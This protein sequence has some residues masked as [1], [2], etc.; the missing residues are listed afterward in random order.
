MAMHCSISDVKKTSRICIC[1]NHLNIQLEL[2]EHLGVTG[3]DLL[4]HIVARLVQTRPHSACLGIIWILE[5]ENQQ[6]ENRTRIQYIIFS[7]LR[8][9]IP[10]NPGSIDQAFLPSLAYAQV[11]AAISVVV[12]VVAVVVGVVVVVVLETST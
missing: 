5:Q 6:N 1:S 11:K 3:A 8:V 4:Q 10:V 2:T 7:Y 9:V 12:V